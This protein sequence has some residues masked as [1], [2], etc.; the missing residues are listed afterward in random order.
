MFKL[1]SL[2][3]SAANGIENEYFLCVTSFCIVLY[4]V[5]FFIVHFDGS[6]Q[7]ASTEAALAYFT[8]FCLIMVIIAI[9]RY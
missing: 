8:A 1:N 7:G 9:C 6:N 3:I 2:L 4:D 5:N